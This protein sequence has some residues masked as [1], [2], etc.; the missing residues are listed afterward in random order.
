MKYL[1]RFADRGENGEIPPHPTEL[2]EPTKP[3]FVSSVSPLWVSGIRAHN[4]AARP[5][6]PRPLGRGQGGGTPFKD[7]PA[8]SP[9]LSRSGAPWTPTR[10][11]RRSGQLMCR[12]KPGTVRP[13]RRDLPKLEATARREVAVWRRAGSTPARSRFSPSA[14]GHTSGLS[15]TRATRP[16]TQRSSTRR[17][18]RP[19]WSGSLRRTSRNE[20][21]PD[22]L[23][24]LRRSKDLAGRARPA[25]RRGGRALAEAKGAHPRG[26]GSNTRGPGGE[27]IVVDTVLDSW[28]RGGWNGQARNDARL[29]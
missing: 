16:R 24:A 1:S 20:L 11:G 21:H 9:S 18:T 25:G 13:S 10:S 4:V 27:V 29:I 22:Q 19:R 28:L 7:P 26:S 8:G 12:S 14:W 6:D 23:R 3:G 15:W 5:I 2:A 17:S